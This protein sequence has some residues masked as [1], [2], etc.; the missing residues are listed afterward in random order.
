[1]SAAVPEGN[2]QVVWNPQKSTCGS[3]PMLLLVFE[4]VIGETPYTSLAWLCVDS[5]NTWRMKVGEKASL[6][7]TIAT[8][9]KTDS[10]ATY[11]LGMSLQVQVRRIEAPSRYL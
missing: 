6:L 2:F 3:F 7:N 8:S 10:W 11:A 1:M 4:R 9:T 5:Q